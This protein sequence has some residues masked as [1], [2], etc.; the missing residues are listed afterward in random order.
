MLQIGRMSHSPESRWSKSENRHVRGKANMSE[1]ELS[2]EFLIDAISEKAMWALERLHERYSRRLY[3]LAYRMTADHMATEELVQ[4]TFFAVWQ[5]AV[6]YAPQESRVQSW[7]FSITYHRTVN[8]LCAIRRHANL[9]QFSWLEVE[10]DEC[11]PAVSKNSA[12]ELK[13]LCLYKGIGVFSCFANRH[14]TVN[15]AN[16]RLHQLTS[17]HSQ[18]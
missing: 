17:A 11:C 4:D 9:Q 1:D 2:D 16:F 8:Y 3:R 6:T 5:S 14:L 12:H 7:L 13:H 10:A 18:P 15:S